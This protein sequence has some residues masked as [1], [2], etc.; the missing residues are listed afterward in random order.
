MAM[1]D[2]HVAKLHY[3]IMTVENVDYYNAPPI[4]EETDE[5]AMSLNGETAVFEM[6]KHFSTE[7]GARA[8]VDEY[9]KRWEVLIGIELEP[10]ELKLIFE[11]SDIIDRAPTPESKNGLVIN[12]ESL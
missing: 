9:I 4:H 8:V 6:K 7:Q 2:P 1:N 11:K 3:K 5:F 12:V 10:D